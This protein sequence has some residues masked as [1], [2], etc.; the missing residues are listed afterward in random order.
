MRQAFP[1]LGNSNAHKSKRRV[2]LL[3]PGEFVP[4]AHHEDPRT[5]N[6]SLHGAPIPIKDGS[7]RVFANG[8]QRR[9]AA[10]AQPRHRANSRLFRYRSQV[11][12]LSP[13]PTP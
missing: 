9:V 6:S 13:R 11:Q 5:L 10:S 12:A 7:N 3:R 1:G 4:Q 2:P 8:C